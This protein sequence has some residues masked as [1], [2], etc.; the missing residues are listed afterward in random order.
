MTT[1]SAKNCQAQ[2][3]RFNQNCCDYGCINSH[4]C[5]AHQEAI[6]EDKTDKLLS[7]VQWVAFIVL[8]LIALINL[9]DFIL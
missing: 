1:E 3:N 4:N 7:K 5:P 6:K 2:T 9:V 8:V